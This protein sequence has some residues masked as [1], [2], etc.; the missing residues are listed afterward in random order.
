MAAY[1][2]DLINELIDEPAI[3]KQ[4][5]FILSSINDILKSIQT[6]NSSKINIAANFGEVRKESDNLATST[7][8]ADKSLKEIQNTLAEYNK[9]IQQHVEQQ[10]KSTAARASGTQEDVKAA[11]A[12]EA[13]AK[14]KIAEE[15]ALQASIKTE[16]QK[17]K[18]SALTLAADQKRIK[19]EQEVIKQIILEEKAEQASIKTTQL[20]TRE[21]EKAAKALKL[22]ADAALK[23]AAANK[24]I[25]FTSN[26]SADG[27]V[28]EPAQGKTSGEIVNAQ[29]IAEVNA[30]AEATAAYNA[31]LIQ[32]AENTTVVTKTAEQLRAEEE[33]DLK[34]KIEEKVLS[35]QRIADLK[36]Q[37]REEN[38]VK[39]SLDQ[40]RLALIRLTAQYDALS[41]TERAT[42]AGQRLQKITQDLTAQIKELELQSGRTGRNVGNYQKDIEAAAKSTGGFAG[43]AG[44]AFQGLRT[45]ANILPGIG[46]AGLFGL[47]FEAVSKFVSEVV[48]GKKAIEGLT[49]AQLEYNKALV[50]GR[51]RFADLSVNFQKNSFSEINLLKQKI[52]VLKATGASA[53]KIFAAE[54]EYNTKR[55][56][57][58][59]EQ[60]T[61]IK[62]VSDLT[63][64]QLFNFQFAQSGTLTNLL[65]LTKDIN[66]LSVKISD[67]TDE[68][69]KKALESQK[70]YKELQLK[71]AKED[72]DK[73]EALLTD[74]YKAET[75]QLALS[76]G[77]NDKASKEA[78]D[79]AAKIF[80]ALSELDKE[81]AQA[82]I[83][84]FNRVASNDENIAGLRITA[85]KLSASVQKEVILKQA[86]D[87]IALTKAT[88]AEALVIRQKASNALVNLETD[89]QQ[90]IHEIL[91]AENQKD[92]KERAEQQ[93]HFQD[94]ID[95]LADLSLAHVKK[96]HEDELK[97]DK[98]LADKKL[99]IKKQLYE[100]EKELAQGIVDLATTIITA[101]NERE[102]NQIQDQ[103]DLLDQKRQK[104]IDVANQTILN[105]QD[106]AAAIT[107]INAKA[108]ADKR[109]LEQRQKQEKLKEARAERDAQALSIF[110][111]AI[112][113]HFKFIAELGPYGLALALANDAL[114]A[115][116]IAALYAKPLPRY[117]GGKKDKY[118]GLAV[119]GDG[120]KA[121]VIGRSDGSFELT[122]AKDTIAFVGKDDTVYPSVEA[123]EKDM[124]NK[125][126]RVPIS[127]MPQKRDNSELLVKALTREF[128]ML[129]RDIKNKKENH[130]HVT[131]YGLQASQQSMNDQIKYFN[132]QTN[133]SS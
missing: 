88:T 50:E 112:A 19:T 61:G 48:L 36:N 47:A 6:V 35:Q 22:E 18:Q 45:I 12:A 20:K 96:N 93:E 7:N 102:I 29:D 2:E 53:E 11:K 43:A 44:K 58:A 28:V 38:A 118:E 119:V 65:A 40:R 101:S 117:K 59:V 103:I 81:R 94:R 73:R 69:D 82:Q 23:L 55:R 133:W 91:K 95:E 116:Q 67:T 84:A 90:K 89:T 63:K 71:V 99:E 26:L 8:K 30:I 68:N 86:E 113:A 129:R 123:F 105:E 37:V 80:K 41:A 62:N 54:T 87:E 131:P 92:L 42:P 74:Y 76:K 79:R 4:R 10:R 111:N 31:Q 34:I 130:Y 51:E 104:D 57:F 78:E 17:T 24:E 39:G 125:S 108:D 1:G 3:K 15:K 66:T 97:A 32:Q 33:L 126:L 115:V 120:G 70:T 85:L 128:T 121:E 52:D 14:A 75:D 127:N 25:P 106:K 72:F 109:V 21:S 124:L 114:A 132:E 27:T 49:E 56:Q 100:K 16:Q 83:D 5:D 60:L 64:E 77:K 13:L 122:P 9:F 46:L 107:T 98:D 110:G